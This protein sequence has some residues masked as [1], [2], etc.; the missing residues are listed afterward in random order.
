MH[1]IRDDVVFSYKI[2]IICICFLSIRKGQGCSSP[3][4]RPKSK[5]DVKTCG[6]I[7]PFMLTINIFLCPFVRHLFCTFVHPQLSDLF[8]SSLRR[9]YLLVNE[10]KALLY[11]HSYCKANIPQLE[12]CLGSLLD[13]PSVLGVPSDSDRLEPN[14]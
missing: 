7:R 2:N 3:G 8:P 4:R 5:S 1:N 10:R 9:S 14:Q 6:H 11:H 12:F 13:Y